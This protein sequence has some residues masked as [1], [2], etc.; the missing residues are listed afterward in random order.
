MSGVVDDESVAARGANAQRLAEGLTDARRRTLETFAAYEEALGPD[1]AVPY[2]PELNPPRWELGHVGWFQDWWLRRNAQRSRGTAADLEGVRLPPRRPQA[3]AWFDSSRVAHATRWQLPLPSADALRE[4]LARALD[5][6]LALLRDTGPDD[7]ALYFHRLCLFHEDMHHEAGVY[8]AQ[9]LGIPLEGWAPRVQPEAREIAFE[10][11][12]HRLGSSERGFAF[13]NELPA[14]PVRLDAFHIDAA[15]VRWDR[16]L[17]FIEAAGYRT[18]R[19]WSAD[20]WAWLQARALA[21]PRDVR[22][23]GASWQ[24]RAFGRWSDIDP[25]APALN[26]SCHEAEAWCAWAG[27]RLPTEAEWEHAALHAEAKGFAWGDVWEWTAS[28]FEPYAGF[29]AH[30]Y[31]DYSQPWF[32]SRRVLR[33][34]SFA[35]RAAVA[36][37]TFRNWDYPQRRQ[38]FA[39]IRCARPA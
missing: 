19:W 14:H 36:R 17:G 38:I 31:R 10:A 34:G 2:A 20:G 7:A 9:H 11:S 12:E 15:P 21:A 13:D 8:M 6:S 28:P 39:G 27:R 16:Y 3:D 4:D 32:G 29:V 26:L 1:L 24:R 5:D 18:R 22:A 33:G 30:P 35:T 23:Q 25:S 37:T